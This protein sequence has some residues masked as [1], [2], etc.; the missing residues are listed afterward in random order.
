[1]GGVLLRMFRAGAWTRSAATTDLA[2]APALDGSSLTSATVALSRAE[3]GRWVPLAAGHDALPVGTD[4][5]LSV[6]S[7]RTG[8]PF[9]YRD[10]RGGLVGF[11]VEF[12]RAVAR[13]LDL[14]L[15]WTRTSCSAGTGPVDNGH[16][17]ILLAPT[18]TLVP[19][20]PASRIFFSTRAA[21]VVPAA[22]ASDGAH[23]TSPGAGDVVGVVAATPITAWARRTLT[24]AGASIRLLGAPRAYGLLERGR[25]TAVTDTEAAA[26]AAIEHRPHLLVGMTEDTGADDVMVVAASATDLLAGVDDAVARMLDDGSYALVFAKYF[27]GATLPDIVGT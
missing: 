20:T 3:G 11:D 25:L 6:G 21:L 13:H 4:G 14:A 27:P 19:G 5:V 23:A 22:E 1:M 10:R 16:I 2:G 8:A 7:C 26:W 9:A 17:D 15:G 18:D 24:E 12:A